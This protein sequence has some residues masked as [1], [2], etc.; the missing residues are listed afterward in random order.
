MNL[1]LV[2]CV[3][4]VR[5][6][7]TQPAILRSYSNPHTTELLYDECRIWESCRAT[8]AATTFFDPI[9]IGKYQQTFLDG[10]VL[11]NNPLPLV[12]REAKN[13][14]PDR[15][16]MVLSIGTGSPPNIPFK[17]NL[18]NIVEAMK[19]ILFQIDT[20]ADEFHHNHPDMVRGLGL[21]RFNATG[22]EAIGLAEHEK[23]GSIADATQTYLDHGETA[24]KLESCI[25]V[26]S[27][28]NLQGIH[29]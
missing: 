11:Y 13:I 22:L 18:K 2:R 24:T 9:T 6:N 20:T 5:Q 26:L 8:S 7:N 12:F 1:S 19:A 27:E 16:A 28:V 21:F 3:I 10:G 4:A 14:W 23:R 17:G 29:T 25:E 15:Q